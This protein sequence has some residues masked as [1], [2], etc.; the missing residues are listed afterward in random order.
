MLFFVVFAVFVTTN[1][2]LFY[3][4]FE[5]RLIPILL[6]ILYWG[7]Q[8][9]RLS[10]GLYFILY[11]RVI[12]L[13]YLLFLLKLFPNSYNFLL[14]IEKV[15]SIFTILLLLPFLVKMPVLGLHFWLPKAHVEAGTSGSIVLAGLLLKLGRYGIF[16]II[17][18]FTTFFL[19]VLSS[20]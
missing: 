5:L 9:E 12:S 20:F 13:P 1:L 18:I 8:P 14:R 17:N 7:N 10:A 2:F 15:S 6:I 19:Q 11:T 3:I 4:I 16:Q